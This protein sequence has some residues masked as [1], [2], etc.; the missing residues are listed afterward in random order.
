MAKKKAKVTAELITVEQE[1]PREYTWFDYPDFY[2]G[3]M[4]PMNEK[5]IHRI[6]QELLDWVSNDVGAYKL[7]QFRLQRGITRVTWNDW[8]S[9]FPRFK[10]ANDAAREIIGNR[11]EIGAMKHDLHYGVV[12]F[13]MPFY[14]PEWKEET[15]RRAALKEGATGDGKITITVVTEPIP[16]SPLVPERIN[17]EGSNEG[18][19]N[20]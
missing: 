5:G 11:R 8:C 14:D 13:T 16:I 19:K 1:K 12:G 7:S 4:R 18:N 2:T 9:K 15:V 3:L 20:G 10:E 6:A 17:R